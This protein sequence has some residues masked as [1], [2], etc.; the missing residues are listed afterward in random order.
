METEL[1]TDGGS[2]CSHVLD[3]DLDLNLCNI[4]HTVYVYRLYTVRNVKKKL[5]KLVIYLF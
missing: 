2:S 1:E 3:L 5:Q 4:T